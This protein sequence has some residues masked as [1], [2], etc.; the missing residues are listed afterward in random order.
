MA[1]FVRP[2]R[3]DRDWVR[4]L[5]DHLSM[6]EMQALL[7][8]SECTEALSWLYDGIVRGRIE[9]THDGRRIIYSFAGPRR[10]DDAAVRGA[11]TVTY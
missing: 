11:D 5:P 1:R 3:A 9:P 7:E 6:D 2:R 4:R 8:P 10:S